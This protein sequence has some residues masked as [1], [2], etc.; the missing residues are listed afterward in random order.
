MGSC[1]ERSPTLVSVPSSRNVPCDEIASP[2]R[3]RVY[4]HV[5]CRK[6]HPGAVPGHAKG[7]PTSDVSTLVACSR[8]RCASRT[9]LQ[10]PNSSNHRATTC[11][12]ALAT[13]IFETVLPACLASTNTGVKIRPRAQAQVS[14]AA[15]VSPAWRTFVGTYAYRHSH[16]FADAVSGILFPVAVFIGCSGQHVLSECMQA[17]LGRSGIELRH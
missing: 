15:F 6:H 13:R 8:A 2:S 10:R 7:L 1:Y 16:S 11:K 14:T 12:P 17:L 9:R 4:R 3:D 5:A